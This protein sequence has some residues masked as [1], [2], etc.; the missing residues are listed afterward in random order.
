MFE[1]GLSENLPIAMVEL[2]A[3]INKVCNRGVFFGLYLRALGTA[4]YVI[5]KFIVLLETV[6]KIKY[7][8][9]RKSL[10]YKAEIKL[11]L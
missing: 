10:F 5:L 1:R 9:I 8:P 4:V 3:F 11:I 6:K 7:Y 2:L